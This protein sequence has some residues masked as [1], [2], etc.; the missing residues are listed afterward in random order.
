MDAA[1]IRQSKAG[2]AASPCQSEQISRQYC[3]PLAEGDNPRLQAG[4]SLADFEGRDRAVKKKWQARMSFARGGEK[5][6]EKYFL[7]GNLVT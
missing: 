6:R 7:L 2:A 4:F 3:L 1:A 5:E